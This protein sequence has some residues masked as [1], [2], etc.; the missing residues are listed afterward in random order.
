MPRHAFSYTDDFLNKIR[1]ALSEAIDGLD[2]RRFT[3]EPKLTS[4]LLGR[5]QGMEIRSN[6]DEYLKIDTTD[7]GDRG[8]NSAEFRAGADFVITAT[9]SNGVNTIRKAILFQLKEGKL[10][11]MAPAARKELEGQI[12][13]MKGVVNAPKI[14]GITRENGKAKIQIASGNR[15]LEGD[16]FHPQDFASYFNQRVITTLDGNTDQATVDSLQD[17]HLPTIKATVKQG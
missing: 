14:G 2:E 1:K 3:Q 9:C 15:F 5:L 6:S 16:D 13:K 4:A 17:G 10:Q 7:V 12:K 11:N 8:R